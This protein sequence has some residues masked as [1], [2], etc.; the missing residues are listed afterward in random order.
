ML[1]LIL[2]DAELEL[3]PEQICNHPQVRA[4]AER[5]GKSPSK[6]LLDATLHHIAQRRL[7]QGRRRGRPDIAHA[8]LL[9]CL[10]SIVN[11]YH[12]LRT[13]IHTRNNELIEVAPET[14][15]PRNY[16][17]FVGLM[18]QLFE[19]NAVPVTADKPLLVLHR[20]KSLKNCL[21]VVNADKIII[22]S[23][24]GKPISLSEYFRS[25]HYTEVSELVCIIGGFP[26][27]EFISPVTKLADEIISI[28][29]SE[30]KVWTVVSEILVNYR[31]ALLIKDP[32][33]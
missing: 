6:I 10:D 5:R 28:H 9:L 16:N 21:S 24:T 25:L 3:V 13:L 30:L 4:S 26:E 12:K 2:A 8:F 32:K 20:N 11:Q 19:E 1:T 14:R 31:N 15:I 33:N 23:S 29:G 22:F 7:S 17:R 18:E 27:G